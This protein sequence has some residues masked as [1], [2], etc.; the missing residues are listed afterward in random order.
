LEVSLA[1]NGSGVFNRIHNWVQDL[2]NSIPVTASRMDAEMDGM[3]TGLSSTIT[4]DGQS[5]TTARIPFAAGVSAAA[6]SPSSAAYAQ[7][8]DLNTGLY[9]PNSDQWG[10][11]AGGTAVLTGTNSAVTV[12]GTHSVVGTQ[13]VSGNAIFG[14]ALAVT[15]DVTHHGQPI[16]PVGAVVDFAGTSAPNGWLFCFGQ[17][18]SRSTY[19]TL[20]TAVGTTYG[21]GDGSTT[22]NLPDLRGRVVAGKDDMG[23]SSANR[24]TNQ[25]GGLNGD[26]LGASGGAEMHTLQTSEIPSHNHGVNDPTHSHT[27]SF[28]FFNSVAFGA[29]VAAYVANFSS[30]N[31]TE[32]ITASSSTTGITIQNIGGG[33]PHNNVQPTF[34]LNKIIYS[35]LYS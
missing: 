7:T 22:F 8:N 3:A 31:G 23:G 14:G 21:A 19:A 6:G 35:G 16:V 32:T 5:V 15:G 33:G 10:L 9:F 28:R 17:A 13:S 12:S 18:I 27:S 1:F 30:S 29:G 20:F 34:I 25:S 4:R 24:L 2:A 11:V 26:A